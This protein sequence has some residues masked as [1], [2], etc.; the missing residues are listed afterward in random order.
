M[1]LFL[2]LAVACLG[3]SSPRLYTRFTES[4]LYRNGL[5]AY[6]QG[7]GMTLK[8]KLK[9]LVCLSLVI[10]GA[11]WILR[12]SSIS[13]WILGIVWLGHIVYFLFGVKTLK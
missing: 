11:L 10:G 12:R 8:L 5:Q 1:V 13:L 6:L 7:K 9:T 4:Q 2:L 3:A